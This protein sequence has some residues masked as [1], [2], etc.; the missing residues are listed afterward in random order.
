MNVIKF[1]EG[2]ESRIPA[3]INNLLFNYNLVFDKINTSELTAIIHFLTQRAGVESFIYFGRPPY[4]KALRYVAREWSD[5]EIYNDNY[6]L[7][8]KF[9]QVVN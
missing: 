9:E 2:Y 7:T 4:V 5:E 8:V 6:T 3:G 1:G